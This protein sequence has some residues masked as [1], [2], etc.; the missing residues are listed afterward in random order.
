MFN[1]L[2]SLD[3]LQTLRPVLD[4]FVL[5][6]ITY[7][8]YRLFHNLKSPALVNFILFVFFI[9]GVAAFLRLSTVLWVFNNIIGWL[10]IG[11]LIIFHPEL[12]AL[13]SHINYN[14]IFS[15]KSVNKNIPN[16]EYVSK[17]LYLLMH[18]KRGAILV[19]PRSINLDSI[20]TTRIEIDAIISPEVIQTIFSHDTSLHD[21]A[22]IIE[23]RRVRYAGCYLPIEGGTELP[24]ELGSRHR[25][26]VTL[27]RNSD[28]VVIVLS[29]QHS[30]I[31]LA[32]EGK[33]L[34]DI[35]VKKTCD[36]VMYLLQ[37]ESINVSWMED[38]QEEQ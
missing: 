12:R 13:I 22:I 3:I 28:A 8:I 25:S 23:G 36:Y 9:Y 26:A 6:L 17:A 38:L 14:T 10:V 30:V 33:L 11:G 4:I 24:P 1:N 27:T 18:V 5:S 29:E 16:L 34:Y 21:G 37:N 7:F 19:F 20:I 31:S 15:P 32:F 2:L 35:G